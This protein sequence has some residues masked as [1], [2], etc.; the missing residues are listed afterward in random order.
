MGID[1]FD[2]EDALGEQK[3]FMC[4][5]DLKD[6]IQKGHLD[7]TLEGNFSAR[8]TFGSHDDADHV[9]N[10]PRAWYIERYLNAHT[11]YWDGPQADFTPDSDDLPWCLVPEKKITIEDIKYLLGSHFQGTPYDPYASYG[12][13]SMR[14]AF[15]SIGV[16][17]TDFMACLQIRPYSVAAP[18]IEWICFGSGVFNAFV[19]M[20]VNIDNTPEYL[21]NTGK[22]VSTDNFYW[23]NR[24]IAALSNAAWGK[25]QNLIERYQLAV[26]SKDH[27]L[28]SKTDEKLAN[29]TDEA[30]IKRICMAA[31]DEIADMVRKETADT[32]DKVLYEA[33]NIMRNA[34]ARSDA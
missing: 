33:S 21:R 16:N 15:R 4:S 12:D 20:Y 23:N 13:P 6:F 28:I 18:A 10:T 9:Y 29:V 5:S 27:E 26:H 7:L 30:E 24:L 3:E 14:G 31:N 22:E 1:R 25:S 19:P 34:Y 11:Y 8:E 17:R 32:L 2:L